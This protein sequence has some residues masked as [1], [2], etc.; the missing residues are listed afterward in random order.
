MYFLLCLTQTYSS[1][2]AHTWSPSNQGAT[3]P[4]PITPQSNQPQYIQPMAV[5]TLPD[6]SHIL[7]PGYVS[8]RSPSQQPHPPPP[9]QFAGEGPASPRP[10]VS[11]AVPVSP[12]GAVPYQAGGPVPVEGMSNGYGFLPASAV[13]SGSPGAIQSGEFPPSFERTVV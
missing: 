10:P 7:S 11:R 12:A 8:P 1:P 4:H 5:D 6:P 3:S 2:A 13:L 9:P